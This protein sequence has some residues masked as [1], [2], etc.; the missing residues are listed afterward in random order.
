MLVPSR[1][2][3]RLSTTRLLTRLLLFLGMG[4]AGFYSRI[5]LK[6]GDIFFDSLKIAISL[7]L[8]PPLPLLSC[9]DQSIIHS[10]VGE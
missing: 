3:A 2:A 5:T 7:S 8:S 9:C 1:L 6:L 10:F 4:F